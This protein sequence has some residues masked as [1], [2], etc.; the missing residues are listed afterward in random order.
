LPIAVRRTRQEVSRARETKSA[1]DVAEVE[2]C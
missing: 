1:G 2:K